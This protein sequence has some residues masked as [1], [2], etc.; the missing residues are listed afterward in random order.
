MQNFEIT[1]ILISSVPELIQGLA[2]VKKAAAL[3]ILE[4]GILRP[5]VVQCIHKPAMKSSRGSSTISLWSM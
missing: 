3:G 1:G 2:Y 5:A 4:L